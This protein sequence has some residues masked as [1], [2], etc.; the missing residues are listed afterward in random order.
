MSAT[1]TSPFGIRATPTTVPNVSIVS[2]LSAP[3]LK[4]GFG[5]T[6]HMRDTGG[7]SHRGLDRDEGHANDQ[8]CPDRPHT[9]LPHKIS[10]ARVRPQ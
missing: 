4:M 3:T 10:Q 8:Y 2:S 1:T 6:V 5:L 7:L 9:N